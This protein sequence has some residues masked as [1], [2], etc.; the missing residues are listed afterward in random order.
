M[1]IAADL[2][3]DLDDPR[4]AFRPPRSR[5]R[6]CAP[7]AAL[8]Q[9]AAIATGSATATVRPVTSPGTERSLQPSPPQRHDSGGRGSESATIARMSRGM[10]V[11]LGDVVEIDLEHLA[12]LGSA[13]PLAGGR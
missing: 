8:S 12:Q 6:E 4:R 5:S 9:R 11:H 3:L 10:E 13:N 1:S 2:K 7:P